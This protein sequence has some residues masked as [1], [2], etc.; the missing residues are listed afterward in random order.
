MLFEIRDMYLLIFHTVCPVSGCDEPLAENDTGETCEGCKGALLNIKY[1]ITKCC[2]ARYCL[3]CA[4]KAS[5]LTSDGSFSISTKNGYD[6]L[7][8]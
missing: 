8:E 4:V 3:Q 5:Y 6:T 1:I 7:R 2:S